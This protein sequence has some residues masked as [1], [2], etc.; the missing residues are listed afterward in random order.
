[1]HKRLWNERRDPALLDE[2]IL[3]HERG[4]DIRN[5]A[6]NG[7]NLAFLLNVRS[8]VETDPA[9]KIAD[10]VTAQRIRRRVIAVCEP[11]LAAPV[12]PDVRFFTRSS[13]AE[14]YL[15]IGDAEAAQRWLT[16]A[17]EDDVPEWMRESATAQLARLGELLTPSPLEQL[18]G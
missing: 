5:D 4:F 6:Y 12:P 8:Q 17:V 11:L 16:L 7:I 15:G 9:D 2:A 18:G 13:L 3:A 14:A 1:M 10:Y